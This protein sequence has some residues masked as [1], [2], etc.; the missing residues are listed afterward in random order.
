MLEQDKCV[1]KA[2]AATSPSGLMIFDDEEEWRLSQQ[3]LLTPP[4]CLQ[5]GNLLNE[6]FALSLITF[7]K[8]KIPTSFKC[9]IR[10]RAEGADQIILM[11]HYLTMALGCKKH[12][13]YFKP[14]E[15]QHVGRE[16][17]HICNL[18]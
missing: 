2:D 13:S 9:T 17:N 3:R 5:Q 7:V 14:L 4:T 18:A 12:C 16:N 15:L 11:P 6:T 10:F 8:R 1:M